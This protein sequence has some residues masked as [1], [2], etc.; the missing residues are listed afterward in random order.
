MTTVEEVLK[1]LNAWHSY[2]NKKGDK[3]YFADAV[4]IALEEVS[5]KN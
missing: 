3:L 5:Q 1:S 2:H 4:K